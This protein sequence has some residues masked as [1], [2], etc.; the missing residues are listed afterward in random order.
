MQ[1]KW[2]GS[3]K[4]D[5]QKAQRLIG[6]PRTFFTIE[7]EIFENDTLKGTVKDDPKTG[8]MDGMGEISGEI[9]KDSIYFEKQMPHNAILDFR[10][11]R[12][13]FPDKKHPVIIYLG[14]LKSENKY[15]GT[16]NFEKKWAFLFGFIPIKYSPGKGTWEMELEP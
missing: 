15:Q 11:G 9:Y 14:Q 4:Y 1:K 10:Q 3:Y 2:K 7:M 6:H 12:R 8:G 13:V 5:S 16:W